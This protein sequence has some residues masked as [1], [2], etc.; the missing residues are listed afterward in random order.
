MAYE[1]LSSSRSHWHTFKPE[2]SYKIRYEGVE[3]LTND[4]V[5]F[6]DEIKEA[7]K[8]I[9]DDVQIEIPKNMY[10]EPQHPIF[11]HQ[12]N[13][14]NETIDEQLGLENPLTSEERREK[15][16][17]ESRRINQEYRDKRQDTLEEKE[18]IAIA[19]QSGKDFA[20]LE[21]RSP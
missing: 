4:Q 11:D 17:A 13:H 10:V 3:Q 2:T 16:H 12:F 1:N 6:V 20:R 14:D 18:R 19:T 7:I 5:R 21:D 9:K 15:Q 8:D